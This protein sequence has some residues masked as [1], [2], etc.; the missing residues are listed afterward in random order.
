MIDDTTWP[1]LRKYE[2]EDRVIDSFEFRDWLESQPESKIFKTGFPTIDKHIDGVAQ[3]E[4]I[5]VSGPRKSGK[6]LWVQS[7]TY[8]M[9]KQDVK[10]L[11]FSYE[12]TPEFF[13]KTFNEL[14][15]PFFVLPRSLKQGSLLWIEER[16]CEALAKFGS[17]V[18]FID[19]LHFLLDLEK[20]R[21]PSIEIGF[22]IRRLKRIAVDYRIVIFILCHMV[23]NLK[24][25]EPNDSD[26]RDSS[27]LS[28]ETDTGIVIFRTKQDKMAS[29]LKICYSRRTG[30]F[31]EKVKLRKEKGILV[32]QTDIYDPS[33][34]IRKAIGETE[35]DGNIF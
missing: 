31:D 33:A 27:F 1:I 9:N 25:D 26:M 2:G 17:G 18:V 19:H 14:G 6:T 10:P 11:W 23:K 5:A 30:V 12:V 16:I 3:G 8:A 20:M 29:W 34:E 15:L 7:V 32:E 21:N 28:Q 13:F 35:E 4:L 24:E 22:L